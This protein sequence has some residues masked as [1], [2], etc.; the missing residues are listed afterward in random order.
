[1][2]NKPKVKKRL[3]K[4]RMVKKKW[5]IRERK[6]THHFMK[7]KSRQVMSASNGTKAGYP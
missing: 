7:R 2:V 6:N 1:M 5:K 4:E 3:K